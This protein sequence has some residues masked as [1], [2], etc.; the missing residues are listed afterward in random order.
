MPPVGAWV[1]AYLDGQPVGCGGIK[2]L[3]DEAAELKRIYL[4]ESARGHS[5]GRR[6]LEQLEQHAR[7][8]GYRCLRLDTGDCQP[9]ALGL[10]R[11]A[12]YVEIPDYNGNT[13]A[14]YWMEKQ[15]A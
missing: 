6:L 2:R 12:G 5:L 3:D 11:S 4:A 9:E 7:L 10:F 15:L 13:W 1:V 14:T 8:L